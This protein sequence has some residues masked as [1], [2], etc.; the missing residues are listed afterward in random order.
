VLSI[1]A[2]PV[3]ILLLLLPVSAFAGTTV[4]LY[5]EPCANTGEC[6]NV[7]NDSGLAV[8]YLQT[9][10]GTGCVAVAINGVRYSTGLNGTDN[11]SH[12]GVISV[13]GATLYATDGSSLVLSFDVSVTPAR[14]GNR[15]YFCL[16]Y[17]L[18]DGTVVL[19]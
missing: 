15:G 18:L 8:D 6:F 9:S 17:A 1:V 7:R 13:R 16:H 11:I 2:V 19:P 10:C 12:N 14:C 5:G 3:A 4:T